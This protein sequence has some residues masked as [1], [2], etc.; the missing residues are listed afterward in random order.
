MI[1]ALVISAFQSLGN[2]T[3]KSGCFCGNFSVLAS[4]NAGRQMTTA[5]N[6]ALNFFM[7]PN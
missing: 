1:P 2:V 3:L 5:T 7:P 6:A 4:T